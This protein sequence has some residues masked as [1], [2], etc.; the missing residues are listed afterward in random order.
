MNY[1]LPRIVTFM[2]VTEGTDEISSFI[3]SVLG[4]VTSKITLAQVGTAVAAI[5]AAGIVAIFAW[6][7]GRKGFAFLKNALSGKNGKV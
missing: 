4:G 5:I 7:F 3:S 1:L 6:K 2:D